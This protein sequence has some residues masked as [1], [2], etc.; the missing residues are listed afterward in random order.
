MR[1]SV[2]DTA[3]YGDYTTGDRIITETTKAEMKKVL[4]EIQD[5]SF[6]QKWLKENTDGRPNFLKMRKSENELLVEKVGGELREKMSWS[7]KK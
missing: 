2:S 6:A 4:S 3:E 7:D 1:Y 5:G